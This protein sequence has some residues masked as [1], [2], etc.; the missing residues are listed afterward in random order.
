VPSFK[1]DPNL[2][3]KYP[4]AVTLPQLQLK[5]RFTGTL[6]GLGAG[7]SRGAQG[8]PGPGIELL[9]IVA[10][11]IADRRRF[12]AADV[13]PAM[14]RWF[15]ARPREIDA[16]LRAALENLRAGEGPEQAGALAWEDAGRDAPGS[17]SLA[18]VGPAIG[19]LHSKDV[20]GLAEDASALSR[21][22][23]HDPRSVAGGVA[24]ATAV[25]LLVRGEKDAEEALPRAASAAGAISDE[26][27][28]AIE[29]GAAKKPDQIDPSGGS[30]VRTVELAFSALAS[31]AGF[32][33]GVAAVVAR[34]GEARVN[35]AV[36][37]ALLGAKL[38]K[39]QIPDKWL[40]AAKATGD[41]AS[42][43]ESLFKLF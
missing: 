22:T 23:H 28:A 25:A 27:R 20:E 17:A 3:K 32:E 38:G 18:W 1:P 35:G 36:A 13:A 8:D 15:G 43:A 5:E 31:G 29:R 37:G 10:R 24:V 34:G 26:V 4:N 33:E 7:E 41:L 40:K 6:L 2:L 39:G 16:L 14:L 21:I 12:E 42:V 9:L 11:S 30:A 19:L